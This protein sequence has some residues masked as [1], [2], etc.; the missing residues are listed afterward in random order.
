[1]I[2]RLAAADLR[3]VLHP[4]DGVPDARAWNAEELDG[5]IAPGRRSRS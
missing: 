3:R 5:L 4:L 1:M 2:A